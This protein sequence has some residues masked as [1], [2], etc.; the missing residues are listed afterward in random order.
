MNYKKMIMSSYTLLEI[1]C[2]TQ[3]KLIND[4]TVFRKIESI[5]SE[6]LHLYLLLGV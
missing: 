3:K 5:N 6:N 4:R 2:I 1:R